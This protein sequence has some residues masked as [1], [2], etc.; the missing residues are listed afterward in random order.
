MGKLTDKQRR[1]VEEYAVDCNATQAAIRAGYSER[2]A[3]AIGR[4]N[5][6]KPTVWAAIEEKL[7]GQAKRAELNAEYVLDNLMEVVERC[8]QRAPVMVGRGEE[9][10]QLID[11]EGRHVWQFDSAGVT[12]ACKLL[13]QHLA[14]YTSRRSPEWGGEPPIA[15]TVDEKLARL[16]DL[17]SGADG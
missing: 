15:L 4:E 6:Q 1:F 10:R 8:M 13:G 16:A 9:R 5:L 12:R 11:E 7:K 2:S 14:L 3:G 17:L